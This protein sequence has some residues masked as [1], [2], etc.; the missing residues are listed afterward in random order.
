MSATYTDISAGQAL[1]P[2]RRNLARWDCKANGCRTGP[3][4]QEWHD[5]MR[6]R[7]QQTQRGSG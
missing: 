5:E 6:R 1:G 3:R 7:E 2:I 4:A